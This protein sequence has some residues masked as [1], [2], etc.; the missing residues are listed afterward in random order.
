MKRKEKEEG[1]QRGSEEEQCILL[2]TE[3][4]KTISVIVVQI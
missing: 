4:D 2:F 1:I 3:F